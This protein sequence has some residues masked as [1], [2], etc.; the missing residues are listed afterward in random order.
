MKLRASAR[1]SAI[2]F[3]LSALLIVLGCGRSSS[4]PPRAQRIVNR[5]I[6]QH[7][8]T[9]LDDAVVEFDFRGIHFRIRRND[10]RFSYA[11]TYEDSLGR[12]VREVLTNDSLYRAVNGERVKLSEAERRS[13]ETDVNSVTYFALLPY[14]LQDPAVQPAYAGADTIEDTAY[15]RIRV[16]FRKEGGGRDWQDRFM[17]WFDQDDY[18][19][20]Y[21]A[22]SFGNGPNEEYGTRFRKAYNVRR[23]NGVRFADYRNYTVSPDT[24]RDLT[25]YSTIVKNG[26]LE[27]VSE[28]NIDSVQV[29]PLSE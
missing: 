27:L 21:L 11:R 18:S 12:S 14:F 9:V 28:V 2:G 22:Y 17:Y 6:E 1:L 16:T 20:D 3:L 19:M 23:I 5:A 7:G 25:R 10:G 29:R 26:N 15:H 24:L 8:G 4:D 13:V